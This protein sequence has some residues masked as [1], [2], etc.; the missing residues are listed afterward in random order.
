MKGDRG[1]KSKNNPTEASVEDRMRPKGKVA[2]I[3]VGKIR[4]VFPR[5]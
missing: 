2:C 5:N 3:S 1:V 4:K